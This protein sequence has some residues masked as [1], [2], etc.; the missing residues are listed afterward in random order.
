MSIHWSGTIRIKN[1][2]PGYRVHSYSELRAAVTGAI[3]ATGTDSRLAST[4]GSSVVEMAQDQ[5]RRRRMDCST[6][7][8]VWVLELPGNQVLTITSDDLPE[9]PNR[10][11]DGRTDA[12]TRCPKHLHH[13][14]SC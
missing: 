3:M 13:L 4:F 12:G 8:W 10:Y 2:D 11:C 7:P 5:N 9:D 1:D 6:P 14:G